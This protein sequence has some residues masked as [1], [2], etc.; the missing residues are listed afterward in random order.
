LGA[1]DP[2]GGFKDGQCRVKRQAA[3]FRVYAYHDDGSVEELTAASADISWT[4]HLV[5]KK[6]VQR[7]LSAP[8][9]DMTIDPG[10]ETLDGHHGGGT[11]A[12]QLRREHP[13]PH[14]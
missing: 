3:R 6:A 8:A 13:R 4:V 9:A 1:P 2:A 10:P 12:G 14:G 11:Q 5:S 7:N